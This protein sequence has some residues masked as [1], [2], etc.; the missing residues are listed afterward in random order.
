MEKSGIQGKNSGNKQK[1]RKDTQTAY[2]LSCKNSVLLSNEMT[3]NKWQLWLQA[4][5]GAGEASYNRP[6]QVS[7][8]RGLE[9]WEWQVCE[10]WGEQAMRVI[11]K[12]E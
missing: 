5:W 10:I 3:E 1:K 2:K 6:G 7:W 12:A 4:E 11:I 8:I 9:A